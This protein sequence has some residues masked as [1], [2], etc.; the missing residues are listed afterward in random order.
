MRHRLE[1]ADRPLADALRGAVGRDQLRML[2]FKRLEPLHQPIVF[3]IADLRRRL[4]VVFLI[5]MA[6]L[7]AEFFDLAGGGHQ[8]AGGWG[9]DGDVP[10]A[11][12]VGQCRAEVR[13]AS[14]VAVNASSAS[15]RT[16][17]RTS[18][19]EVADDFAGQ[20]HPARFIACRPM[21]SLAPAQPLL[22]NSTFRRDGH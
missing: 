7:L 15:S 10:L 16:R 11:S 1:F 8:R 5:V 17:Q 21:P 18:E 4:D 19:R 14:I 9:A 20:C 3:E 12:E 13:Y 6:N 22:P 2:R